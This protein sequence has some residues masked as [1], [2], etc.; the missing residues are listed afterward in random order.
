MNTRITIEIDETSG[1][2]RAVHEASGEELRCA[3]KLKWAEEDMQ[4]QEEAHLVCLLGFTV[5]Q[6]FIGRRPQLC[7]VEP[8][9][10]EGPRG[11]VTVT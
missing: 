10:K 6:S 9:T 3:A 1:N 7:I 4:A 11:S 2:T 5:P 8:V